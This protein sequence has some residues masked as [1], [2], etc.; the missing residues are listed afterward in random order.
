[1]VSYYTWD[2]TNIELF[3]PLEIA[4]NVV[5]KCTIYNSIRKSYI[6]KNISRSRVYI[7][8]KAVVK[9][10]RLEARLSPFYK[11]VILERGLRFGIHHYHC[12]LSLLYLNSNT[13][14]LV[15]YHR[16]NASH[17]SQMK[18]NNLDFYFW[19]ES[20]TNCIHN[21]STEVVHNSLTSSYCIHDCAKSLYRW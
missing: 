2:L 14:F 1:M 8:G 6:Y 10:S 5:G 9:G 17:T 18:E 16:E 20:S 11:I 3:S 7:W 4:H 21:N 13:L 19:R 12:Q 15:N